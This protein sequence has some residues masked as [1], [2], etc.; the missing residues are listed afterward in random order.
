MEATTKIREKNPTLMNVPSA[1]VKQGF[2]GETKIY[3]NAKTFL[4]VH[5]KATKGEI[6]RS[7]EILLQDIKL[8]FG[9]TED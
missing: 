8:R 2:K 5:P 4:V 3:A 9:I 6:I 7:V 1:I